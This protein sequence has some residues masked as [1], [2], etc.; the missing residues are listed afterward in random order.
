MK[1]QRLVILAMV[2]AAV[3]VLLPNVKGQQVTMQVDA[4]KTGAPIARDLYGFFSE[5]LTNMYEGGLWAEMLGDRKFFYPVNSSAAQTPPNSRTFVGRWRPVGPDADV[6]MDANDAYVGAHSP[7]ILLDASTPHGIQ[8]AGLGLKAGMKYTGRVILAADRG[9]QVSVSLIWGPNP[10]DRQTIPIPSA[11]SKYATYPFSF[12]AGANTQDAALEIAGIGTGSFHIGAVSLMPGDN[13]DGF[14]ADMIGLYKEIGPTLVRWPGGNFTSGYDWRDGIGDP[15]K[16]S[17]RYDF[18]WKALESNDMGIDDYMKLVKLLDLD[19]YICV[20]DGFGDAFSAAQELE[21]VNGAASTPMGKLRT[22]NGH[23]EPYNVKWWNVGNEMY[24]SWQLGHMSLADYVVKQN[25]FVE[26]MR[27][28]DPSIVIVASGADPAEMT[29]TGA[30]K[31]I[32]GK[33]ITDFGDPLADWDG[34]LLTNSPKYMDAIAEHLY[35]QAEQAFDAE[36]GKFV[37]V[38]DSMADKA[39]RLPNRVK[40]VTDAWDE[41]QKRFPQVDMS[42]VPIS[43]DEWTAGM[44]ARPGLSWTAGNAFQALSAAEAMNE[45]FRHSG[46]FAVSAYTAFS[47]LLAYDKTDVTVSPLGLMFEVY[48]QHYGTIPVPVTGNSPQHDV[49]GTV[50]VD[51]PKVPSGSDTYPLDVVAAFTADRKTLTIAVVNPT[52][53]A[54]QL[55]A[56][57]TGVALKGNGKLWLIAPRDLTALNEPGKPAV[58]NIGENTL[59]EA[60]GKL[61]IPPISISIYELPVQ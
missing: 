60:P 7:Q 48:R 1:P 28:V 58:V 3:G 15:D 47:R 26:A 31:S 32:T 50:N 54:Q 8:Q 19:P 34:G 56:T 35:P 10:G 21:Y 20:N 17:P 59:Q 22:A 45:M 12:T 38:N 37:P 33:P 6:V 29:S 4:S 9:A 42:K 13:I 14:R 61:E 5:F 57:F 24:G 46:L 18:S 41:Y 43:L 39:R 23:P 55:D 49:Q 51:K 53:S 40:C 44:L 25:M 16:R 30:G 27:K 52:E 2:F 36:Q 11:G